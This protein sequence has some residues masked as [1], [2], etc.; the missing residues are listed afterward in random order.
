MKGIIMT[1]LEKVLSL[2]NPLAQ[3]DSMV[4]EVWEDGEI[5]LTKGADLY[6]HRGLHTITY[7]NESKAWDVKLFPKGNSLHGCIQCMTKQ[8]AELAHNIIIHST[9]TS[10][11]K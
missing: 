4:Y 11:Y 7:G 8:D 1:S 3:A 5:T 9:P 2:H 6:G 10:E